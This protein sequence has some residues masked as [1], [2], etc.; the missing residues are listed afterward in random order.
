MTTPD[1]NSQ[2]SL[3]G[4]MLRTP[5]EIARVLNSLVMRG[6]PIVSDLGGGK[7]LFHSRLRFIDPARTYII[8]ELSADE[9]ANKA[10]LARPRATFHAEP[11]GWRVEFAAADPKHTTAHEGAPGIRLRFP[12]LVAGH[13]RRADERAEAPP[14][15]ELRCVIDE[16]GVMPFDGTMANVSK[17]GIGFLQY[18]PKISL[19]P[20]TVLKGCHIYSPDGDSIVVDME[21]RYSQLVDLPDGT[22]VESSGCCF[23]NLSA[24]EE[25][26]IEQMFDLSS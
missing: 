3:V 10:L 7:R 13:R 9:L 17:G 21:V 4:Q 19:E 12:E 20:G 26:R 15:V 11:G 24:E 22:Q 23:M 6:E 14:K 18:D 5:E 25:A 8:V 1:P 16:A 2:F